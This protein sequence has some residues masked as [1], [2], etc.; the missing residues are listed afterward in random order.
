MP[1]PP[2]YAEADRLLREAAERQ[3]YWSPEGIFDRQMAIRDQNVRDNMRAMEPDQQRIRRVADRARDQARAARPLGKAVRITP[4]EA[5]ILRKTALRPGGRGPI[6]HAIHTLLHDDNLSDKIL[7]K[8]RRLADNLSTM[9]K[10]NLAKVKLAKEILDLAPLHPALEILLDLLLEQALR[11]ATDARRHSLGLPVYYD[12]GGPVDGL[13]TVFSGGPFHNCLTGQ[14]WPAVYALPPGS[15]GTSGGNSMIVQGKKHPTLDRYT[16][17]RWWHYPAGAKFA[18]KAQALPNPFRGINPNVERHL[19]G[20]AQ[21]APRAKAPPA[22]VRAPTM[23][24]FST[25]STSPSGRIPRV[26]PMKRAPPKYYQKERGKPRGPRQLAAMIMNGLDTVSELS[27]II[28]AL[29][30]ALPKDVRRRY[31]RGG[32]GLTD[33]AGQYGI[34]GADY[35]I[36][37]I[38]YNFHRIDTVAA[39]HNMAKNALEDQLVGGIAK[40]LPVNVG[41]VNQSPKAISDLIDFLF[42]K[43][44]FGG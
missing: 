34:D 18:V 44:S 15:T 9:D 3:R 26:P 32:R 39:V 36:I 25:A 37:A 11:P 30:D 43:P 17:V 31:D 28:D 22:P 24:A 2:K 33:Q 12:C 42:P 7:G 20:L 29:Y 41:Q 40:H 38:V 21:A 5:E 19:P 6:A 4:T 16:N 27:E 8:V 23:V 35:K 1:R 10:G 14:A 13:F